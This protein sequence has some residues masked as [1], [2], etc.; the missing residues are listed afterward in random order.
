M[1]ES[2]F[3][4][5][6]TTLGLTALYMSANALLHAQGS[7]LFFPFP[8]LNDA[9]RYAATVYGMM[10]SIPVL[11]VLLLLTRRYALRYGASRWSTRVPVAF[12][13]SID[14]KDR[15]GLGPH[16]Q[17]TFVA[18]FLVVPVVLQIFLLAKFFD[19]T[20][21]H[22][23]TERVFAN[24][25]WGHLGFRT[26]TGEVLPADV[27]S[28]DYRYG[29]V[30]HGIDFYPVLQSWLFLLLVAVLVGS[31]GRCLTHL[32]RPVSLGT[33]DPPSQVKVSGELPGEPGIP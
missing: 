25:I 5:V 27:L 19:G 31:T 15:E 10:V 9:T 7:E 14:P 22:E 26:G 12:N 23:A 21:T 32:W 29:G 28:G 33:D 4:K 2:A 8:G 11:F 17:A 6:W 18:A 24:D 30:Q 3:T 13:L 20:I 1:D 16:Y